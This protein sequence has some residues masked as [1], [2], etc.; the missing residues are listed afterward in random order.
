[1]AS[2]RKHRDELGVEKKYQDPEVRE[3]K[4]PRPEA[5]KGVRLQRLVAGLSLW[6]A[7]EGLL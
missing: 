6:E 2:G 3:D 5:T 4:C 1:M 7:R